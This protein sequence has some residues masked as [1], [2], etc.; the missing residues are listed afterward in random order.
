MKSKQEFAQKK[1]LRRSRESAI[2]QGNPKI[3]R[4]ADSCALKTAGVGVDSKGEISLT[5]RNPQVKE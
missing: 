4:G 3:G 2:P 5:R 1:F